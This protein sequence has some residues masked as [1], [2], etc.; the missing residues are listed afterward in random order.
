MSILKRLKSYISLFWSVASFK[1]NSTTNAKLEIKKVKI[2]LAILGNFL[3][4][5]FLF[6][7]FI[8]EFYTLPFKSGTPSLSVT[9]I[10]SKPSTLKRQNQITGSLDTGRFLIS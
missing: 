9:A 1:K 8:N 10:A 6:L 3:R 7:S 4:S 2:I 5:F